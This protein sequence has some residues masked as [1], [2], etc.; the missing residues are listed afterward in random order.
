MVDN[1]QE[2][3]A[4]PVDA[5]KPSDPQ[6]PSLIEIT[7]PDKITPF[8][9]L[10][11]T[12]GLL[13]VASAI[14]GHTRDWQLQAAGSLLLSSGI[15]IILAAFGGQA[16]VRGKIYVLA[17]VA[18][19]ALLITAGLE[20]LRDVDHQRHVALI[21]ARD[22][23]YVRGSVR[24]VPGPPTKVSLA[25]GQTVM[26]STT[27]GRTDLFS[28]AVF[29]DQTKEVAFASLRLEPL[30]EEEAEL[31][32]IAIPV[33]CIENGMG[34]SKPLDWV[35]R[36]D[37]GVLEVIDQR[38]NDRVIGRWGGKRAEPCPRPVAAA[39]SPFRFTELL[40]GVRSAWA[41]ED[42]L[43]QQPAEVDIGKTAAELNSDITEVRRAA[44][45]TLSAVP[46]DQV[47][48]VL[49]LLETDEETYRTKLGVVVALTEMLRRD[50]AQGVAVVP[51]LSMGNRDALLDLAGDPDRTVRIYATEFL[52][53]LGDPEVTKL[54]IARAASTQ[55]NDARYNWLLAAQDGWRRLDEPEKQSLKDQ[56]DTAYAQSGE[57]TKELFS[58]FEN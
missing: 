40:P 39:S 18:A 34:S 7:F 35:L 42:P 24:D 56:L 23:E 43:D 57:R 48:A 15:A 16:T 10:A 11:M 20:Y 31:I 55:N 36:K 22:K 52:F 8:V 26:A 13:L 47:P 32:A 28:F 1:Q 17:G 19:I 27:I 53:D 45:N 9:W 38:Q 5:N 50:K 29:G 58:A 54:A 25:F 44:R 41:Q 12:M 6:Q 46:P 21:T 4:E 2:P 3:A 49:G 33:S 14:V 51:L 30:D 37:G